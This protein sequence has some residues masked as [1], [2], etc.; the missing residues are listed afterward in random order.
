LRTKSPSKALE[1]LKRK[2]KHSKKGNQ[3]K[4]WDG[5][6]QEIAGTVAYRGG[7]VKGCRLGAIEKRK[8]DKPVRHSNNEELKKCYGKQ[9][10]KRKSLMLQDLLGRGKVGEG[11][12]RKLDVNSQKRKGDTEKRKAAPCQRGMKLPPGNCTFKLPQKTVPI[13]KEN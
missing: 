11:R 2:K 9:K 3:N 7:M 1:N 5:K 4:R 13:K 12:G 8:Q 10:K 6:I